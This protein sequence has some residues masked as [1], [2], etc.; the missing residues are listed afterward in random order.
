MGQG[1]CTQS[2]LPLYEC[3]PGELERSAIISSFLIGGNII[4]LAA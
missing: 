1:Y 4:V 2:A 3:L